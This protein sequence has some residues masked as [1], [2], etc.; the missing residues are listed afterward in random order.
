MAFRIGALLIGNPNVE[1]KLPGVISDVNAMK[2][3]LISN[4]GGAWEAAEVHIIL[5]QS[6]AAIRDKVSQF[7]GYDFL[8]TLVAGHGEHRLSVNDT[9]LCTSNTEVLA[10]ND[11]V[12]ECKR[13][14]IIVDVCRKVVDDRILKFAM[15]SARTS[16]LSETSTFLQRFRH[17]A[18]YIELLQGTSEGVLKFY[19]CDLNQ[20]AG[21]DGSGGYYT[22]MLLS[23]AETSGKTTDIYS[24]H[25]ATKPGVLRQNP[26]Q[27]PTE[28][29]GR[30]RDFPP[31]AVTI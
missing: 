10:I 28:N 7:K 1:P 4:R 26:P 6:A 22:K 31:F 11:I 13:Q 2:E 29:I 27:A 19:S 3:Y 25:Q 14:L 20:T 18:R 23:L 9:V 30:R 15:D 24:L 16:A 8:F 12:A 17:R 5:N 21:D